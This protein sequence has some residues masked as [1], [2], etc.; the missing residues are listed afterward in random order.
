LGGFGIGMNP[1]L[2]EV[3]P[4]AGLEEIAGAFRQR[5]SAAV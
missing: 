1:H 3:L 5:P 2:A 4:E